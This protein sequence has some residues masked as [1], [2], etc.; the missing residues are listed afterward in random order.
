MALTAMREELLQKPLQ[1]RR[2]SCFA[3]L[4]WRKALAEA[5]SLPSAAWWIKTMSIPPQWRNI[6]P[7]KERVTEEVDSE[8]VAAMTLDQGFRCD[9]DTSKPVYDSRGLLFI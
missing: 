2:I 8:V 3:S 5:A 1:S 7:N 9:N 6:K 4:L